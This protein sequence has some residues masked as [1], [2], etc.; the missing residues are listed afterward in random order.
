MRST[1]DIRPTFPTGT[2]DTPVTLPMGTVTA[3]SGKPTAL[4]RVR[5]SSLR[6][7]TLT[8]SRRRPLHNSRGGW[9]GWLIL[10]LIALVVIVY[11]SYQI[12]AFLGSF[13]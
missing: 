8:R 5:Y 4:G 11:V 9:V 6:D 13:P 1:P 10:G 7:V 12:H 2:P 3:L